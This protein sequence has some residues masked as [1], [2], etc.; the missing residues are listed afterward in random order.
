MK[1]PLEDDIVEVTHHYFGALNN[2]DQ[3]QCLKNL[4]ILALY[5]T[6]LHFPTLLV[7]LVQIRHKTVVVE[8]TVYKNYYF[9]NEYSK[10]N[11]EHLNYTIENEKS[12]VT[13]SLS[14]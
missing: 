4:K 13:Y 1:T 9:N 14:F 10:Y 8:L 3:T 12:K 2:E 5:S 11:Y 6:I 7:L